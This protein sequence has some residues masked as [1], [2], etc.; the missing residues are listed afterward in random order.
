M[1]N[2]LIFF[3][4]P[5]FLF[6]NFLQMKDLQGNSRVRNDKLLEAKDQIVYLFFKVEKNNSGV[7]KIVL[8][9]KKIMEG[10]LK[11]K[12]SFDRNSAKTGD[13]I[14]SLND[15]NGKEIVK[16]IVGDP[17][18]PELERFDEEG[19]SRN[20]VSLQ[21]AEFSVRYSHSEEIKVVRVEKVTT[22]GS[23]LLFT[24]KL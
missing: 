2:S 1:K 3:M 16:Q 19:M 6:C 15:A 22:D 4:F 11:S 10:R 9:D 18:N 5:V 23:Q 7:E 24:Q 8:E 14:I 20:K 21:N 13:F 12:P 17:L